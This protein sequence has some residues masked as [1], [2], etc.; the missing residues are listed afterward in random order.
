MM[1]YK[2]G[3]FFSKLILKNIYLFIA[4]GI[5]R[6]SLYYFPN[7][8][9]YGTYFEIYLLPMA[10]AYS[11]GNILEKNSGGIV[12]I[13]SMSISM[14]LYPDSTINQ[15]IVVGVTSGFLIKYLNIFIK[16]YVYSGFQMFLFNFL[17]PLIALIT[18]GAFY[19]ILKHTN[20][21]LETI[22][23]FLIGVVQNIY[24]LIILT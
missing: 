22:S 15:G 20:Y 6:W 4:L 24:G 16:K 12:A 11:A 8:E 10:L 2:I 3:N 18:G 1:I 23:K 21:Y 13:I 17:Y 19:F 9:L 14:F 5:I 7:L